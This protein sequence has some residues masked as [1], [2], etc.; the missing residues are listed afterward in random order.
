MIVVSPENG[1][2]LVTRLSEGDD[3]LGK[4]RFSR[5]EDACEFAELWRDWAGAEEIRGLYPADT[6]AQDHAA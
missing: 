1:G 6:L 5:R 3:V 4:V 2:Y